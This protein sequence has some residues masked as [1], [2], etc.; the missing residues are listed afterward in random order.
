MPEPSTPAGRRSPSV[1]AP[2]PPR[3]PSPRARALVFA[4]QGRQK[5]L[6]LIGVVF[7]LTGVPVG[8]L[9]GWASFVDVA[10]DARGVPCE[11]EVLSAELRR[12]VRLHR[13]NPTELRFRC[14]VE[15]ETLESSSAT[16]DEGMVARATVGARLRGQAL[17]SLGVARLEGT[18]YATMGYLGLLFLIHPVVGAVLAFVAVRSNR[19]E[20][21][22]FVHGTAT[23]GRV[24]RRE[25]DR[26]TRMNRRRPWRVVWAFEVDGRRYEGSLSH[27]DRAELDRAIPTDAVVVLYDPARPQVSTV[28]VA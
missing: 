5:V 19:R 3:T 23:H 16:T 17:P 1:L 10:L 7:L 26:S 12:D 6:L 2:P 4:Y 28:Y 15:G 20:I 27:M 21:R 14:A 9:L 24:V 25:E 22:A 18:T 11:A 13:R 8:G